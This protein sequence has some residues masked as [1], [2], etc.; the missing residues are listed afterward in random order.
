[1]NIL[2][3]LVF[4]AFLISVMYFIVKHFIFKIDKNTDKPS[5]DYY[6][7]STFKDSI[8][9]FILSYCVLYSKNFLLNNEMSQTKIFTNEPNF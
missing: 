3:N 5:S 7:K 9:I 1:M 2:N 6:K 4:I 8:L